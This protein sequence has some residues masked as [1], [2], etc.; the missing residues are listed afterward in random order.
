MRRF[1]RVLQ[2]GLVSLVAVLG[3]GVGASPAQADDTC[4]DGFVCL[5]LSSYETGSKKTIVLGD[6]VCYHFTGI[7]IRSVSSV[8][9]RTNVNYYLHTDYN[10]HVTGYIQVLKPGWEYLSMN[11]GIDNKSVSLQSGS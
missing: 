7:W 5:W 11:T 10:C 2:I 1:I 4:T 3:L 8:W 9:N 6:N